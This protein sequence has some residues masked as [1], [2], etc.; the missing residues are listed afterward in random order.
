MGAFG[1]HDNQSTDP[2]CPKNLMLHIKFNQDWP[3]VLEIFMFESASVWGIFWPSRAGNSKVTDLSW[4][5]FKHIQDF[6]PVLV[7]STFDEDP[8]KN[9]CASLE[10]PFSHFKSMANF[11][12]AQGHL[13]LK[14]V[15]RS[16]QNSNSS[17]ILCLSALPAS[18]KQIWSK[19]TEKRWRHLFPHCTC[20]W[21]GAFPCHGNQ[22]IDPICPKALSSLSP[23]LGMLHIEFDQDWQTGLRDIQV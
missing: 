19:T 23:T 1:C 4:T 5:K 9:E 16:G 8:I 13:T 20:K 15:A 17:K 10:T 7:T 18:L 6:M 14:G 12:N 22:S 3:T 21:L 11:L 2:I